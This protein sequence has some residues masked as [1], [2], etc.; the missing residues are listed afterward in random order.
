MMDEPRRAS[1]EFIEALRRS[2]ASE[3]VIAAAE[4]RIPIED[5]PR[6][7]R[8]ALRRGAMRGFE[9]GMGMGGAMGGTFLLVIGI[10]GGLPWWFDL[11]A[12]S[13]MIIGGLIWRRYGFA[14]TPV[15]TKTDG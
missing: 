15:R 8:R 5:L 13:M 1:P 9:Q 14:L 12:G 7:Y 11:E 2:G 10:G 6:I 3:N 4:G